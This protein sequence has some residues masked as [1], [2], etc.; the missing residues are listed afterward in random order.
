MNNYISV[1]TPSYNRAYILPQLYKSLCRQTSKEFCWIIV[2]DGSTD[3]TEKL[4]RE[5]INE[6]KITIFYY[7]Q[8]NGGKQR[9][10]NLAVSK[11][12][13]ELFLGVDSDDFITDE[14]I[15]KLLK[16]W[17]QV[18]EDSAVAGVIA[19]R[20][21]MKGNPLGTLYPQGLE[22]TTI[23]ELY[24][25]WKFK[26]DITM[27]FRTDV[28]K[29]YPYWVAEGEKFIGEGYVWSQIDR[30]YKLVILPELLMLGEYLPDGYTKNVRKLTKDNPQSYVVLKRQTI[31]FSSSLKEKYLQTI[32]CLVGCI[33]CGK[34]SKISEVPNKVLG[35]LAYIPAWIAWFV[36][37]KNA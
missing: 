27:M 3:N 10:H 2:D 30:K 21:D 25:K 11:C 29:Q 14:C 20:G 8:S 9:A 13:T 34:K 4:V 26:G 23:T 18:K 32:L 1:F 35:I 16:K 24:G 33:L 31:E 36:F 5:W 37:Y 7:K 6:N 22:Y 28:L 12:R 15:E 17:N 19:L